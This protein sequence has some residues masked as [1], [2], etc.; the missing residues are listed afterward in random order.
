M[1]EWNEY[2]AKA[3][4]TH[5][6]IYDQI[7]VFYRK[8]I[9]KP[10]LKQF[11]SQYFVGMPAILHAGCGGGQ[12]EEGIIDP[13]TVIGLDISANALSLYK[14]NHRDSDLIRGDIIKTGFR[15]GCLEGIYN[16]GVM[17]H[18]SEDDIDRILREFRRILKKNGTIILFW[19]PRYGA[20]VIFLKGVHFVLNTIL[21][22]NVWLHPPEPSL[23]RSKIHARTMVQRAGFILKDYH[24]G[25]GDFFT[26]AVIVLQKAE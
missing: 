4:K 21:Q 25:I 18:F 26:Y 19:P 11:F 3:P 14:K 22:K 8:Y 7:A 10:Y 15:D 2:W 17:E 20:T 24:F 5:N 9:I 1:Q 6:R 12:V 13:R 23:I 16:L